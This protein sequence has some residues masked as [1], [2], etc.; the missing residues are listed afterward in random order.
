MIRRF[1]YRLRYHYPNVRKFGGHNP[2]MAAYY[3]VKFA[4]LCAWWDRKYKE[5]EAA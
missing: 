1:I 4:L 2:F 3:C 5:L